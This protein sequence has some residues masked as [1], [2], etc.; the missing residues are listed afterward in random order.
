ME[1]ICI[2]VGP[3][4]IGKTDLSVTLARNI[5][6]EII[7]A[8]S[9]QVYKYMD[10]GTAKISKEEMQG[11]KHYMVNEVSPDQPFSVA[12]FRRRAEKYITLISGE[13][14]LPLIVGGTGLYI[15]SLLNNL[16]FTSSF[17]D[18]AFRNEMQEIAAS[19]G[20]VFLHQLL[21]HKDPISYSKLYPNDLRRV[22]RALE[23]HKCTGKP[24]SYFQE[25]SKKIPPKYEFCYIGLL[26]NRKNLYER[27]DK[28]VDIMVSNGLIDEVKNLLSAGYDRSLVSMQALG[29]KEIARY[30]EGEITLESAIELIKKGSRNYAKRQ[31][32]WF[33][34]DNR[35]F[36]MN[37]DS[38]HRKSDLQ[39]N[40][41]RY[42]AGK[43]L[44]I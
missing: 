24:I 6:A 16:D 25:E 37:T 40:I 21:E 5:C 43:L 15:N 2:L 18:E 32:T 30:L 28:R 10:I 29:Y 8:D 11:V 19:K 4:A 31:L 12:E 44:L 35:V 9:A 3:T 20:N 36:W 41:I 27:I 26:M 1:K 13:G 34:N 22:I 38:Y 14:K 39:E 7:S 42:V 33:R 23:V 17:R